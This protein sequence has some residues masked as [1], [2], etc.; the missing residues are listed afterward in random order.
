M[1]VSTLL[2]AF[3]EV[4]KMQPGLLEA[5]WDVAGVLAHSFWTICCRTDP[6][7]SSK[8]AIINIFMNIQC[9]INIGLG[10]RAQ[11]GRF[12]LDSCR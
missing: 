9:H 1:R 8:D 4:I 2:K 10:K 6:T 7:Q 3:G 11:R 12:D 5:E